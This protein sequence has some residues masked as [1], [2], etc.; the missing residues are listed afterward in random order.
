MLNT[1]LMQNIAK[2]LNPTMHFHVGYFR[3][4]PAALLPESDVKDLV[5]EAIP[6]TSPA[7]E[8]RWVREL[9]TLWQ[10]SPASIVRHDRLLT[11]LF[12][13]RRVSLD[14][15]GLEPLILGE[16]IEKTEAKRLACLV[17]AMHDILVADTASLDDFGLAVALKK[18][19]PGFAG[20][21]EVPV[22]IELCSTA[23]PCGEGR[24]R[25]RFEHLRGRAEQAFR[26]LSD[27]G[28]DREYMG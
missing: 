28:S 4:L 23:E 24:H 15:Q 10:V 14:R 7:S 5:T 2:I 6:S 3:L 8:I 25:L 21:D 12:G 27:N 17:E 22:L 13:Y 20:L 11:A 19:C 18:Q 26:V 16:A 1:K 9:A